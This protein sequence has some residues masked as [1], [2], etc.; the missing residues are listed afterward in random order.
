MQ[1]IEALTGVVGSMST[2]AAWFVIMAHIVGGLSLAIGF[3]TR[4]SAIVN[5]PVLLGAVFF[6]H[7]SAGIFKGGQDLHFSMLV[8]VC[9]IVFAV[10]GKGKFSLDNLLSPD[11]TA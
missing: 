4:L 7:R 8:L 9:L 10:H 5:I 2:I 1:E 6:V 3:A 11:K